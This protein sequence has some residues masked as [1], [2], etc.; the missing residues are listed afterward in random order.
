M[1]PKT[2]SPGWVEVIDRGQWS[3]GVESNPGINDYERV[4][5][6]TRR[7]RDV[8]VVKGVLGETTTIRDCC[9]ITYSKV[10]KNF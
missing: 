7:E 9:K 4:R 2:G 5:E 10:G 3:K 6:N 1:D 8:Q